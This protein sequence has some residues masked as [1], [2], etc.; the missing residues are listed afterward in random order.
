MPVME[1]KSLKQSII[2][3]QKND[4]ECR[5]AVE[6]LKFGKMMVADGF[7]RAEVETVCEH[8]L[9]DENDIF[10]WDRWYDQRRQTLQSVVCAKE[11]ES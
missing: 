5:A 10:L 4:A 3:E 11:A 2:G 9:V 7:G 8:A 1:Q 6:F